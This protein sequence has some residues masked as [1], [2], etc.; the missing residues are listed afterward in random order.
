MAVW[1]RGTAD[2][3]GTPE[4][5]YEVVHTYPHKTD[6]FTEGLFYLKG[7]L[8]EG[9]GLVGKSSIRKVEIQTGKVVQQYDVATPYF[10]EGIVNWNNQLLQLTLHHRVCFK[11]DLAT[12]AKRGEFKY[13]GQGWGLTQDGKSIIMSDSTAVLRFLDPETFKEKHRITVKDSDG[14]V[15]NL[16]ELELVKD[17][18]YANV[19]ERDKIA[20]IE[21]KAG[22]VVGWINLEHLW[23]GSDNWDE[24]LNGIAY[25]PE[26]D[27]LFVTGKK[28][29]YLYEIRV[30]E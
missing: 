21:P 9:T 25:D 17:K 22:K 27:R 18:I 5:G 20:I 26:G 4:Y 29:P 2:A 7:F 23:A 19:W 12:F 30:K 10:G 6:A 13:E 24:T 15:A 16:N 14:P 28:W 8:Y 3:G 11:Y 1:C